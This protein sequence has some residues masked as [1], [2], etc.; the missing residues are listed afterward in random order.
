MASLAQEI[1]LEENCGA[2]LEMRNPMVT[3]AYNG[4][5][6]YQPLFHAGCLTDLDGNYCFANAVTNSSAPSSSYVYY[7]PLGVQLP[8]GTSPTCDQC[9][10][11]TMAV[12]A[13]YA[14][15]SSQSLSSTYTPAAEQLDMTCGPTFVQATVQMSSSASTMASGLGLVSLLFM[16]L[17]FLV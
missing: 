7:L 11:N 6:A 12:F 9:L 14:G 15:N 5:I 3:Q 8:G 1:Q 13:T 2:D 4:F 16:V 17:Q 10:K